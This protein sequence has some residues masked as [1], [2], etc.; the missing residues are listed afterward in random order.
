MAWILFF[1]AGCG[2]STR[3]DKEMVLG[4]WTL[5][6]NRA[7]IL[8]IINPKGTWQSSVRIADATSKIV[9]NKGDADGTWHLQDDQFIFTV[10]E[11]TIDDVWAKNQTYVFDV[12]ELHD[13]SMLLQEENGRKAEWKKTGARKPGDKDE[14]TAMVIPM[15]PIAVNLNKISSGSPDR[16][17]CISMEL[18]LKELMPGQKIPR[19]HPRA[20]EAA[21][22]FLSSLIH[23][24]VEDFDKVR[25]QKSR[26]KE[27]LNPYMDGVI[28]D[29]NIKRVIVSTS[30]EKV[31]EFFIEHTIGAEEK[32]SPGNNERETNQQ[33]TASGDDQQT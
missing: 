28:E 30:M 32:N 9:A 14:N 21:I 7:Y 2:D 6:R 26:L 5:Q 8:L 17:L 16:Y 19:V 3:Q 29:I 24:D 23:S 22:V 33:D 4:N 20:K 10:M 27:V 25:D 11:S 13:H 18:A 1:M 15:A 12:V 31:E